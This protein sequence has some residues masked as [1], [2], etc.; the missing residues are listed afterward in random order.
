MKLEDL[1]A[2]YPEFR[3]LTDKDNDKIIR[4]FNESSMETTDLKL[5]YERYPNFSTFLNYQSEEYFIMGGD[6][7]KKDLKAI[8]TM[9]VREGYID[10][11]KKRIAYLGD[12]RVKG[13]IRYS[14]RWQ[15]VFGDILKYSKEMK[16]V[17]VDLFITAVMRGNKKAG[18][19]LVNNKRSPYIYKK[20]C[21]YKM[22][23][24]IMPYRKISN[25]KNVD[26]RRAVHSD[27]I[28][29]L[30]FLEKQNKNKSF[31]FTRA[32]FERVLKVWDNFSI[33]NFIILRENGKIVST[34]ATWNPSPAKKIIVESLPP[35]L[36]ILNKIVSPFTKTSKVGEELKVQY[37]NF[38][39]LTHKHDLKKIIEF[40]RV[41]A[42]FKKYDLISFKK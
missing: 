37:L 27:K 16:D 30:N 42:A 9:S 40:L 7:D 24:L 39:T 25:L 23:N 15:Q 28:E 4:F 41:E 32:Y 14:L 36:K 35:S 17:N 29:L 22:V 19:A 5:R 31:G 10:G 38:L 11:Q 12:L 6:K 18:Q 33:S 20:I 1:Y 13:G 26:I 2:N 3:L 21:D 8:A 34:T